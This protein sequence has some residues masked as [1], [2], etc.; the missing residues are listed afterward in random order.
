VSRI[1][2]AVDLH[3]VALTD[4]VWDIPSRNSRDIVCRKREVRTV[5]LG[6]K[7]ASPLVVYNKA[8]QNPAAAAG[9][10]LTRVEYRAKYAGP[11]GGLLK[12]ANPLSNV[13]VFD[14]GKLS[15]PDP[16]RVALRSVGHLHGWR[17]IV[18][19]FPASQKTTIEQGLTKTMA[20]WWNPVEIWEAWTACLTET[21]PFIFEPNNDPIVAAY[22]LAMSVQTG[23]IYGSSSCYELSDVPEQTAE[24]FSNTPQVIAILPANFCTANVPKGN[25]ECT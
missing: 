5:Y 24:P 6:A 11:V 1:D 15:Y 3:G 13:V 21:L 20:V 10:D 12:M 9:G 22:S 8:K 19:T 18:R 2:V 16:H 14:P 23:A 17:G 7:R 25:L 4:W